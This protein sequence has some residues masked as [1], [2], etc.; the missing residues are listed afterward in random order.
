MTIS[1][2]ATES[3]RELESQLNKRLPGQA[4]FDALSRVLYSTDASTH[5]I[6]PLGV[7]FPRTADDLCA[8]VETAAGLKIP[9]LPRGA[10]TG[11]A[12]QTIGAALIIDCARHLNRVLAMD[13]ETRTAEVEPG[14]SGG[15]V[16]RQTDAPGLPYG[17]VP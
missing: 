11:L 10:G 13:R 16:H 7:V 14:V 3:L 8:A 2:I 12:G 17:P 5:Q 4:H 6:E 15:P 9:V 1:T